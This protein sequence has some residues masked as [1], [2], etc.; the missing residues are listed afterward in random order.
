MKTTTIIFSLLA[1]ASCSAPGH[2][3]RKH[4]IRFAATPVSSMEAT[5]QSDG[6]EISGDIEATTVELAV[7]ET[8]YEDGR[9]TTLAEVT[10]GVAEYGAL[11]AVEMSGGGRFYIGSGDNFAPFISAYFVNT[12]F[13][14]TDGLSPGIHGGLRIGVGSE[15]RFDNGFF[16]DSSVRYLMTVFSA[17]SN[18]YPVITTSIEGLSAEVGIG[19]EF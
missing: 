16:V 15:Y 1:F 3:V 5:I 7:G 6:A 18:S 14:E 12:F 2:V 8:F 4:T 11:A 17:E 9:R 19:Y 10:L 13:E